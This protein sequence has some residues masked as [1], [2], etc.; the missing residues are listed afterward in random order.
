[1]IWDKRG[2]EREREGGREGERERERTS[3]NIVLTVKIIMRN[4]GS[5]AVKQ[6]YSQLREQ[7]Y[8]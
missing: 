1:M 3:Q 6:T 5:F 2:R 7:Q 8:Y 4:S